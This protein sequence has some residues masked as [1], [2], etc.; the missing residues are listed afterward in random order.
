MLGIACLLVGCNGDAPEEVSTDTV[1]LAIQ[2]PPEPEAQFPAFINLLPWGKVDFARGQFPSLGDCNAFVR[3]LPNYS[4]YTTS[5]RC[6]PI[7]DPVYC[8]RWQEG[9]GSTEIDC[10]RGPRGCEVELPRHDMRAENDDRQVLARCESQLLA[11][12]WAEYQAAHP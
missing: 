8:T 2:T 6:E 4:F 7:E 3:A 9:Q 10:F 12:A 5:E 11:D 1:P